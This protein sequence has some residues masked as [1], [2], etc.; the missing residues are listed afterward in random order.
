MRIAARNGL[1]QD[2]EFFDADALIL[3]TGYETTLPEFMAPLRSLLEVGASGAY[4][5]DAE[6]RAQWDGPSDRNIFVQNAGRIDLGI[7]EPQLSLMAWRSAKIVNALTGK[8][9]F[10]LDQNPPIVDW[11]AGT[12]DRAGGAVVQAWG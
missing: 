12:G 8:N 9:V 1:N 7:F 3:A 2:V 6:F 5:L 10:N 11:V 4:R